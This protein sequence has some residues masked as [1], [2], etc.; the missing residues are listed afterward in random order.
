MKPSFLLSL[1]LV[2]L[3]AGCAMA[4]LSK[5]S[6]FKLNQKPS[7]AKA[8]VVA[9]KI[10]EKDEAS[11]SAELDVC[12]AT[13]KQN[14][15]DEAVWEEKRDECLARLAPLVEE[16]YWYEQWRNHNRSLAIT[17]LLNLTECNDLNEPKVESDSQKRNVRSGTH[18]PS[19]QPSTV[20]NL[21][22]T[23]F[24]QYTTS[25]SSNT[26]TSRRRPG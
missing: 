7:T 12:L 10:A 21:M 24:Y 3:L 8:G 11:D 17:C 6:Q 1:F 22:L 26:P 16:D 19:N 25:P 15:R 20:L 5:S 14:T 9:V 18:P 23:L 13:L 2:V 4:K